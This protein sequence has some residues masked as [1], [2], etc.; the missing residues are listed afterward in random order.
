MPLYKVRI[1]PQNGQSTVVDAVSPSKAA[2]KAF[3]IFR[4]KD[5]SEICRSVEVFTEGKRAS[6]KYKIE[7]VEIEHPN[8]HEKLHNIR[9][10]NVAVRDK[11]KICSDDTGSI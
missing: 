8:E 7:R 4:K 10:R 9:H 11:E 2:C 6:A 5:N 1:F 3:Q